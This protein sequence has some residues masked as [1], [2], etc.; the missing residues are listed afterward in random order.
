MKGCRVDDD[1][2]AYEVMSRVIS[3]D[4]MFLSEEHTVRHAR[5]GAI[6]TGSLGTGSLPDDGN[7][8]DIVTRA[9]TRVKEILGTH[10]VEPLSESVSQQLDE[11]RKAAH[12]GLLGG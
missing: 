4:G 12:C 2:L 6:W 10:D 8:G 1:T 7:P 5:G 9:S 3:T 11:I